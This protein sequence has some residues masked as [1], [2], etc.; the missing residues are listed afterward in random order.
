MTSYRSTAATR[1]PAAPRQDDRHRRSWGTTASNWPLI[2]QS[3]RCG[4][5]RGPFPLG[6]LV[7]WASASNDELPVDCRYEAAGCTSTRRQAPKELGHNS[8][9]LAV[10]RS[11]WAL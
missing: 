2:G 6:R 8:I 11:I 5:R 10:D 1:P 9:E 3:G 4:T 7:S